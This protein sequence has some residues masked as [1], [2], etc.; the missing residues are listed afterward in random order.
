MQNKKI[1]KIGVWAFLILLESCAF[2]SIENVV[3]YEAFPE[4][5]VLSA[6]SVPTKKVYDNMFLTLSA[7]KLVVSSFKADTMMYFYRTPT[8]DYLYSAGVKGHAKNEMQS[9]P[10]FCRSMQSELYVRGFT[11]NSIRKFSVLDDKLLE[12]SKFELFLIDVPNDMYIMNDNLLYYN[13]LNSNIIKCYNIQKRKTKDVLSLSTLYGDNPNRNVLLGTLCMNDSL[14]AYAFQYKHEIVVL[15]PHK[16]SYVK[17]VRWNYDNQDDEVVKQ[18]SHPCLYYTD[19][20]ATSNR[21]YLLC[22]GVNSRQKNVNFY[23]E[24]YNNEF[25]PIFKYKLDRKIFKFVVDENNGYLYGFGKS[26]EYIYRYK[27]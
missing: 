1:K 10:T 22:R 24:V 13:D 4:D 8:L 17:T 15:Q 14:A 5:K 2:S 19:G 3:T 12:K 21:F 20:Y 18:N 16:K 23:I 27:L 11:S 7:G 6:D 9:F 26:D 25:Q